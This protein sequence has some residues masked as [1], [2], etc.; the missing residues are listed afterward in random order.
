MTSRIEQAAREIE[1]AKER[2]LMNNCEEDEDDKREEEEKERA[3]QVE[4][5]GKMEQPRLHQQ[6][7]AET[8]GAQKGKIDENLRVVEGIQRQQ[9]QQ[10]DQSNSLSDS[11]INFLNRLKGLINSGEESFYNQVLGIPVNR[12]DRTNEGTNPPENEQNCCDSPHL[13]KTGSCC[14]ASNLKEHSKESESK[15]NEQD[16]QQGQEDYDKEEN[17]KINQY[18]IDLRKR[19]A[20]R[21]YESFKNLF[22]SSPPDATAGVIT[23]SSASGSASP[24]DTNLPIENAIDMEKQIA[25][26]QRSGFMKELL[27]DYDAWKRWSQER[28]SA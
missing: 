25:V 6:S 4:P 10:G 26:M 2:N 17:E 22:S 1:A 21:N 3:V 23:P 16:D 20:L 9:I 19:Q 8:E 7:V 13:S 5:H 15:R 27:N 12:K 18:W 28:N 14:G 24:S 11:V